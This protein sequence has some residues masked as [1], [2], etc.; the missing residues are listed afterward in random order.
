[1][2]FRNRF[3]FCLK[4]MQYFAYKKRPERL[5]ASHSQYILSKHMAVQLTN[6]ISLSAECTLITYATKNHD[7]LYDVW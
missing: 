1:M 6:P 3:Y 4:F 5:I 2:E 7:V